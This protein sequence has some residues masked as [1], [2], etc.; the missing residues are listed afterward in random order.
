VELSFT[1]PARPDPGEDFWAINDA[2][3]AWARLG[4]SSSLVSVVSTYTTSSPA[5]VLVS[6][7]ILETAKPG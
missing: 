3:E 7:P 2:L 1:I 6:A 5:S 4:S